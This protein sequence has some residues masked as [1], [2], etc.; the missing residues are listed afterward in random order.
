[1]I[2]KYIVYEHEPISPGVLTYM[3]YKIYGDVPL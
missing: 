2:L 1:M 3:F